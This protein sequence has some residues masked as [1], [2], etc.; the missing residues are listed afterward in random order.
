MTVSQALEKMRAYCALQDRCMQEVRQKLYQHGIWNDEAEEVIA[1]LIIEGFLD[2]ERFARSFCRGKF[3][4]KQWGCKKIIFELKQRNISAV[5]IQKA[6]TEI[7]E[8]EYLEVLRNLID[9]R[10]DLPKASK[11]DKQKTAS[12]LIGKGFEADL[13]FAVLK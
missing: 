1:Q 10:I 4:M 9:K 7:D 2:E 3:R 12:Y 13:V 11:A 5:C 8:N 6:L